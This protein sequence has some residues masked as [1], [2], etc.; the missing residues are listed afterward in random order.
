MINLHKE[1]TWVRRKI[2]SVAGKDRFY[3]GANFPINA[4]KHASMLFCYHLTKIGYSKP[5]FLVFGVSKKRCGEVG[6]WWVESES[7]LVDI[8]ADQFNFIED[9]ELS[10]KIKSNRLYLPVYCV[11]IVNAPHHKIFELVPKELWAWNEVDVSETYL[12]ELSIFYS[13]LL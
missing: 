6:H 11:P 3:L 9:S 12:D 5:I 1:A 13:R 7:T 8:T 10:Y 4:C 2:E